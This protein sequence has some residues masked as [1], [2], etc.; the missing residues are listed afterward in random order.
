MEKKGLYEKMYTTQA[1]KY[2]QEMSVEEA[3]PCVNIDI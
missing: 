1:A 3:D 2:A